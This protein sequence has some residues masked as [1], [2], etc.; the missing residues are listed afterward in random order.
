MDSI[1]SNCRDD[2]LEFLR[3]NVSKL[4]GFKD[5]ELSEGRAVGDIHFLSL[6]HNIQ[7]SVS[8]DL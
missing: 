1:S 8:F 2:V 3:L 6:A 7:D 4:L 5:I